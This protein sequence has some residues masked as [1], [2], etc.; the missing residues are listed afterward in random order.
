MSK[1]NNELPYMPV[2][3]DSFIANDA[4]LTAEEAG[5]LWRIQRALW[6]DGGMLPLKRLHRFA[7]RRWSAVKEAVVERLTVIEDTVSCQLVNRAMV[8]ASTRHSAAVANAKKRWEGTSEGNKTAR[9]EDHNI[10]PKPLKTHKAGY[11]TASDPHVQNGCNEKENSKPST[12]S[13]AAAETLEA[14]GTAIV[15]RCLDVPKPTARRHIAQWAAGLDND[16][17]LLELLEAHAVNRRGAAYLRDVTEAVN[18]LVSA[19][20]KGGVQRDLP[21]PLVAVGGRK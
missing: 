6:R 18:R 4:G 12:S 15:A 10:A 3:V 14:V 20:I 13:P 8:E 1:K 21:L 5:V 9:S 17:Q 16:A 11:A 7:G 19:R 2:R